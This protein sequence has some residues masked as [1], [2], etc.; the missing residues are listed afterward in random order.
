MPGD[1]YDGILLRYV[2][3]LTDGPTLP[4]LSCEIQM[5]R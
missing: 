4:T 3:P 2:N 1:A 5:L